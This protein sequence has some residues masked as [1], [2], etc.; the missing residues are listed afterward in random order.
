MRV[1]AGALAL[2]LAL[3]GGC[4]RATYEPISSI[5][6]HS[7]AHFAARTLQVEKVQ[8]HRDAVKLYGPLETPAAV[9]K[10]L[11]WIQDAHD[12]L[13]HLHMVFSERELQLDI[14]NKS[15]SELRIAWANVYWVDAAGT[16]FRLQVDGTEK[17][18]DY[19]V[20]T[21][22][23]GTRLSR[24]LYPV[25]DSGTLDM[26][27]V[28]MDQLLELI[29]PISSPQAIMALEGVYPLAQQVQLQLPILV[30]DIVHPYHFS[31]RLGPYRAIADR[32]PNAALVAYKQK[33][34]QTL[35]QQQLLGKNALA[36]A[37]YAEAREAFQAC[38]ELEP[39][40]PQWWAS[41]G[42]AHRGLQQCGPARSDFAEAC[43][44]GAQEGC[45][46]S[47]P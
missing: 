46:L 12:R 14:I 26:Q 1:R 9:R 30:D 23:P 33:L 44:R 32:T 3:T 38:L 24:R 7:E 37:R 47:C 45:V 19:L 41:R 11:L 28:R 27:G 40:N 21:I 6:E 8:R 36:Q 2:F 35:Q 43:R 17:H 16:P 13:V 29:E 10:G 31:F 39:E 5:Q 22:A 42:L 20:S 34:R 18:T 25:K 4:Y 15:T